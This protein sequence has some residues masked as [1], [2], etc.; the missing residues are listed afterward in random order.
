MLYSDMIIELNTI[1]RDKMSRYIKA[2]L[3]VS[4]NKFTSEV[5]IFTDVKLSGSKSILIDDLCYKP[6][7][8]YFDI[9]TVNPDLFN[10]FISMKD[11]ALG[12]GYL[13]I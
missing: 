9:S 6:W 1:Q 10:Q 7:Y 11:S 13:T 4:I 2:S 12:K 5:V 8:S 3:F